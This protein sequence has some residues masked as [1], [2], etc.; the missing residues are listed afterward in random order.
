MSNSVISDLWAVKFWEEGKVA[1]VGNLLASQTGKSA[2]QQFPLDFSQPIYLRYT[3]LTPQIRVGQ[4]RE[5]ILRFGI[6]D[7]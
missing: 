2:F 1:G 5:Q 6:N 7:H 4:R 3:L